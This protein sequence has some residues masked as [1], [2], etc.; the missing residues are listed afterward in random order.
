MPSH[1]RHENMTHW[2]AAESLL[3]LTLVDERGKK[4]VELAPHFPGRKP[5]QLRNRHI[6]I[7]K[8]REKVEAG[9]A[10]NM[11]R[12]CGEIRSSHICKGRNA[13]GVENDVATMKRVRATCSA[14]ASAHSATKAAAATRPAR[15]RRADADAQRRKPQRASWLPTT[16]GSTREH[17]AIVDFIQG[18]AGGTSTL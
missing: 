5:A 6:R 1:G 3:L 8:G 7:V 11:C 10:R 14:V 12:V 17:G 18:E 15:G 16:T 4:W 2:E 13:T 9:T